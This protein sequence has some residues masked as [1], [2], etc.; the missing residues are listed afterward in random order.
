MRVLYV[1]DSLDASGGAERSLASLAPALVS[2]GFDM[3]VGYLRERPESVVD[4]LRAGGVTVHSLAGRGGRLGGTQRTARLA[5]TLQTDLVHTTL[6]EADQAG[7]VGARFAHRPVVS[8]FVSDAYSPHQYASPGLRAWKLKAAQCTDALTAHLAVR[9]HAITSYVADVMAERLRIRRDRID[10]VPRGR[11]PADLHRCTHERR[12][13]VRRELGVGDRQPLVVA[14][15]RQEWQ[16]GHDK[17]IDAAIALLPRWPEL[18][19]VI[20]GR[21]GQQTESLR[22]RIASA[23]LDAHVRI[24][25]FRQDVPDLL[26]AAD[27]FAFPSRWEGLGSTLLEAMALEAPI[28]ASDLPAVREVLTPAEAR[29]VPEGNIEALAEAISDVIGNTSAAK[30]RATVARNRFMKE[31]TIDQTARMTAAFYERATTHAKQS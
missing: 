31:F 24:L 8:S 21:P 29:L 4:Q 28:V 20:A 19:V 17:L 14:V 25:G 3:H 6:F 10:V 30:C 12:V 18:V 9:F 11:D 16:K 22:Q 23:K 27:V 26:C 13:V 7:R 15:G 5:R 1:I 2:L